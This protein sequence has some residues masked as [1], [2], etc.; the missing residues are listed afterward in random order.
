MKTAFAS[1]SDGRFEVTAGLQGWQLG[2][3]AGCETGKIEDKLEPAET[4]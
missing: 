2:K 4:Q 1:A 3:K